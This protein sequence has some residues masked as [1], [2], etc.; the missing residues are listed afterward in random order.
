MR[1]IALCA[2]LALVAAVGCKKT[3]KGE[4]SRWKSG[5]KTV[6]ELKVLYPGFKAPLQAQYDKAKASMDQAKAESDKDARIKKMSS[7]NNLLTSGFV[8]QLKTIDTKKKAIEAK[9]IEVTGKA[10]DKNDRA[11]AQQASDS[12]KKII[13]QVDA[14]L[15]KGAPDVTA[16]NVIVR[17]ASQDLQQA[18]K[19]LATAAGIAAQKQ[20]AKNPPKGATGAATGAAAAPPPPDPAKEKWVCDHCGKEHT[21]VDKNCTNCGASRPTKK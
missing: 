3:E 20:A 5:A 14:T 13:G 10:A 19:L 21:G 1:K 6:E 16:A 4:D 18:E 8:E 15:K 17:K 12:A 2:A 7:A 11:T 9:I